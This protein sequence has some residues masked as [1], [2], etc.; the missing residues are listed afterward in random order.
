[1]ILKIAAQFYTALSDNLMKMFDKCYRFISC[2][3]TMF[4]HSLLM[5]VR[6]LFP[7]YFITNIILDFYE[8]S[9]RDIV[10][11]PAK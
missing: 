5:Q 6:A 4:S 7:L 8:G 1:M 10:S 2:S 11:N 9:K 3:K